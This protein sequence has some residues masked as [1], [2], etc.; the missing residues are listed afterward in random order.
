MV[1]IRDIL[2]YMDRVYVEQNSVHKVYELGLKIFREEVV[3][4]TPINDHLKA[5]LLNMIAQERQ[6]EVIEW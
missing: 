3:G 4:H 1:M 5:T 6:K 2:M